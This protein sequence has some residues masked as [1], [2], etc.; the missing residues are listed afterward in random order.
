MSSPT[1]CADT[2]NATSS[3]GSGSGPSPC[4]APDGRTHEGSGPAP[5]PAS[6]SARQAKEAGLLTSGTCG[7]TGSISSSTQSREM[8]LS[9]ASRLR[10]RTDSLGSTL[11]TLTWK[12]RATPSGRLICALRASGRRTSD[13]AC[14]SWPTPHTSSST[15]AGTQGREGGANLQT[16]A[17]WATPTTKGPQGRGVS[18][19]ARSGDGAGERAVGAAGAVD[20]QLADAGGEGRGQVGALAE[21]SG[22]GSG[23]QG[24][25][26]RPE[27]RGPV[28]G[29]WFP[30]DWL[31]CI[32][33]KARP[34]EPGTFPL[35]H[36][37]PARVGRLRGYGNAIVPQVGAVVIES[38][39]DARGL[40]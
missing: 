27:Y 15:G 23:T 26:Q 30:A 18:G 39:M 14:S 37:V 13:S 32:D 1:I 21:G 35:A 3:P 16:A 10:P 34:V 19:A 9:L 40:R 24:L 7:L 8:S 22:S 36:G 11:F 38:Y 25:E 29:A 5:A 33:G 31:P 28:N 20:D 12:D 2:R 4:A 17:S 6:L